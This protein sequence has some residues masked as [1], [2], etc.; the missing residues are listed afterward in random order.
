MGTFPLID[1]KLTISKFSGKDSCLLYLPELIHQDC[2][3]ISSNSQWI[4]PKNACLHIA[5]KVIFETT[6]ENNEIKL[7][8][9]K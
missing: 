8:W 1:G 2:P 7:F 5:L 9:H 4:A 6:Y 3:R